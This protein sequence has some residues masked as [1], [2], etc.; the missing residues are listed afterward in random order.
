MKAAFVQTEI[1][2]GANLDDDAFF[3]SALA[4]PPIPPDATLAQARDV[5]DSL[6]SLNPAIPADVVITQVDAN[7]ASAELLAP[8]NG[9]VERAI[10]YARGGGYIN[11][12]TPGLWRYPIYRIAHQAEVAALIVNYR[13]APENTFPAAR[14]DVVSAYD[15]LLQQGYDAKNIVLC[16]DS[17]G[18]GLVVQALLAIRDAR[19]ATPAGVV[20]VGAWID[21]ANEGET[22][23]SNPPEA[24]ALLDN[25]KA[26]AALYLGSTDSKDPRA[27]PLY[28][29]LTG[30]PPIRLM[31]GSLEA[32]R[33]D[34]TRF[35]EAASACGVDVRVEI[36]QNL[37]H[38]WYLFPNQ[39]QAT[40]R[41]YEHFASCVSE[42]VA[43]ALT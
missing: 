27:N 43:H 39:I 32:L 6:A 31:V 30:M 23:V 1:S 2:T 22:R 29:D 18:G 26:M 36:W 40:E 19:K 33:D 4:N 5:L 25:L 35:A 17:S 34:S 20:A 3:A 7:G 12:R 21:L 10:I 8:P 28:A 41:T 37:H 38:G 13:L 15:Y 11:G 24:L 42:L 16:G 14:D 9:R